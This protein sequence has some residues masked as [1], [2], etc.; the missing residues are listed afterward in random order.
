MPEIQP[1]LHCV[2]LPVIFYWKAN[3]KSSWILLVQCIL[4]F[5]AGSILLNTIRVLY[6]HVSTWK[7][8][9]SG[10]RNL[11]LKT[12]CLLFKVQLLKIL[13]KQT[14]YAIYYVLQRLKTH[15]CFIRTV[16][17]IRL[18]KF[19]RIYQFYSYTQIPHTQRAFP[20]DYWEYTNG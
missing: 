19:I 13:P 7:K 3:W 16:L 20:D 11:N 17:Y 5:S 2:F 6:S 14:S 1:H 8:N 15:D 10:C 4:N 12:K 18:N 9:L